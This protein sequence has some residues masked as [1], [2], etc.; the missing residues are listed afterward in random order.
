MDLLLSSAANRKKTKLT[1]EI[2]LAGGLDTS[3]ILAWLIEQGYEVICFMANIGQEEDFE[4][5]K[6]KALKIGAK[7]C[8]VVSACIPLN[9]SRSDQ[10][11]SS[12][13]DTHSE[14][15]KTSL[16]NS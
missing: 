13:S 6:A 7:K 1:A 2:L 11:S 16:T 3:V 5:A 4:A 9:I 12:I 14:P 15:R 10:P 8:Y